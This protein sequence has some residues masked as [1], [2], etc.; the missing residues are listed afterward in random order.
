MDGLFLENG[1]FRLNDAADTITVNQHSWHNAPANVLY[2]DQPVGTGLSYTTT[3]HY[4]NND[5]DV[6]QMFYTF[7]QN[8]LRLHSAYREPDGGGTRPVYFT[9]ESHAG[10]YIP[11]MIKY[12]L[13]KNS[14]PSPGDARV[15]L[16]GALVGNGWTDH[17]NGLL[18][19]G[20]V[21]TLARKEKQCQ[22]NLDKKDYNS[23][24]CFDLVDDIIA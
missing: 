20:Q 16:G 12:I 17:G 5:Q 14:A 23:G 24:V 11:S 13:E 1:P 21:A 10:H 2:I 18:S 8:F 22:A 9:G 19:E 4:A 7:L 15:T 6:N 3:N